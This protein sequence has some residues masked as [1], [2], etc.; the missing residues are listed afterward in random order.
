MSSR[1]PPYRARR[2][3]HNPGKRPHWRGCLIAVAA[4]VALLLLVAALLLFTPKGRALGRRIPYFTYLERAVLG[5]AKMPDAPIYGIDISRYQGDINWNRVQGIPYNMVTGRQGV[6][7]LCGRKPIAFAMVKATEGGNYVDPNLPRNRSGIRGAGIRFGAY[8]VLTL[9]EARS[10]VENYVGQAGLRRGDVVPIIDLEE[11][12]LGGGNV[13]KARTILLRLLQALEARFHAKPI[14]YCSLAFG[15]QMLQGDLFNGYPLWVARYLSTDR[16]EN[17][18]I[19]QFSETGEIE[20]IPMP[21]DLNA[22][23]EHRWRLEGL[24]IR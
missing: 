20:G 8:H 18:D 16:P 3:A 24:L 23:Y 4:V 15:E 14:I 1:K 13:A 17:A 21:V 7:E 12:I 9:S 19:W 11:S 5:G 2:A 22:L 6:C 10:Q